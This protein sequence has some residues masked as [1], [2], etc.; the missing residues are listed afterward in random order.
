[1]IVSLWATKVLIILAFPGWR[2][3]ECVGG[4]RDSALNMQLEG[5]ATT[6][7]HEVWFRK[8]RVG[9]T[10]LTKSVTVLNVWCESSK[11]CTSGVAKC[12]ALCN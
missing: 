8:T 1:M 11:A 10:L 6:S 3:M 9:T 2:R 4:L 12:N 7:P 5:G